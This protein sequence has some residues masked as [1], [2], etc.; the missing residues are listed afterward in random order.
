M[1]I[2]HGISGNTLDRGPD[3][4]GLRYSAGAMILDCNDPSHVLARTP[5]AL[6]APETHDEI[7]GTTGNVVFPTAIEEIDGSLFVFYG[8][9]DTKIGVA[10]LD[11]MK[12]L[13]IEETD[14]MKDTHMK[15]VS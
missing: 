6:L 11:R 4:N 14:R 7:I 2:Y 3:F 9:A 5:E 15:E 1:L 10:R 8:M 13:T 12:P